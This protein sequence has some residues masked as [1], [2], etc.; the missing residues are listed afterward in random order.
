MPPRPHYRC[1]AFLLWGAG[2]EPL[3]SYHGLDDDSAIAGAT[4]MVVAYPTVVDFGTVPVNGT[5]VS[6]TL[7]LE[8]PGSVPV[9][10]YGHNQPIGLYGDDT[11][12]FT[13]GAEPILELA[14]GDAHAVTIGFVPPTDGRW[15]A[16]LTIQ[17]GD[18]YLE[19]VGRGSAPV[20]G[21]DDPASAS[22]TIGCEDSVAVDVFNQGSAQLHIS[23]LELSDPWDAWSLAADPIPA[24][25]EP[26]ERLRVRYAFAPAYDDDSHGPRPAQV[27]VYSNDPASAAR[28]LPL[29]GLAVQVDGVDETFTYSP[30]AAIDLLM[31]VDTDG[32]MGLQVPDVAAAMPALVDAMGEVGATLHSAVVT[33]ASPCPTTDPAFADRTA[34]RLERSM[35]LQEGLEGPPGTGSD[36]LGEHTVAALA[37]ATT[38]ACL[39]GFLR[40]DARLHVLLVAGDEDLST[41]RSSTQ[42]AQMESA[43]PDSARVI[44]ST[45]L[46]TDSMGCDGTVYSA[47]YAELAAQ[48]SG[49]VM[50]LCADDLDAAMRQVALASVS[51]LA[52][53]LEHPLGREPIPESLEVEVD[54]EPFDHFTYRAADQTIVF[55]ATQPPRSGA[56]VR[57]QYR[58]LDDCG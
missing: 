16:G 25:I 12:V 39:E 48:S 43:A 15:E 14:P 33:G 18:Q 52:A 41:L 46:P 54:G 13:F 44:V 29:E 34:E 24:T 26:G 23:E 30:G 57:V 11:E 3:G 49:A 56:S 45:L 22:A 6:R 37:Q 7:T 40:P 53:A 28:T 19:V 27:T 10:V 9:T 50:D 42:L 58:A 8:N 51:D 21:V 31:V 5:S 38:G 4:P 36:R 2:C 17:P 35:L 20:L 55:D 47:S 32:V 1:L